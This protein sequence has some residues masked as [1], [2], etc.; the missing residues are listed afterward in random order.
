VDRVRAGGRIPPARTFFR[1]SRTTS[2]SWPPSHGQTA[3]TR[4]C[5]LNVSGE[6]W[7][8]RETV[9]GPSGGASGRR[10]HRPSPDVAELALEDAGAGRDAN[11]HRQGESL[12]PVAMPEQPQ[13]GDEARK[14]AR[15]KVREQ[16]LRLAPHAAD[17]QEV[18]ADGRQA[19]IWVR[20]AEADLG[21]ERRRA[22]Q[23]AVPQARPGLDVENGPALGGGHL[24]GLP[25]F[26]EAVEFEPC[27]PGDEARP[28]PALDVI[29][30]QDAVG[31]RAVGEDDVPYG[32]G[33]DEVGDVLPPRRPRGARGR[34]VP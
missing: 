34:F 9:T 22:A 16:A 18:D 23:A 3:M 25:L 11:G 15:G 4:P 32:G 19:G 33:S 31:Q 12:L 13:V 17:G 20:R 1:H 28:R 14:D 24:L 27:H 10:R 30:G 8:W 2:A 26:T 5:A 7:R 6:A 21:L 29:A